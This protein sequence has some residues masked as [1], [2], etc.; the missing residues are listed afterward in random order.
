VYEEQLEDGWLRV[1]SL[2]SNA[3][4]LYEFTPLD[5]ALRDNVTMDILDTARKS[6]KG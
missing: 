1:D 3:L 2:Q 5:N 4:A 6:M